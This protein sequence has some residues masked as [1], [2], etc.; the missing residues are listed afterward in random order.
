VEFIGSLTDTI[1]IFVIS[2]SVWYSNYISF[3]DKTIRNKM[4]TCSLVQQTVVFFNV[5][6][7]QGVTSLTMESEY[8]AEQG[9]VY[10][11]FKVPENADFGD[12]KG[13]FVPFKTV[14]GPDGY[15]QEF[16]LAATETHEQEREFQKTKTCWDRPD[17][18]DVPQEEVKMIQ[19]AQKVRTAALSVE[20]EPFAPGRPP[21]Q[22]QQQEEVE[23]SM[24]GVTLDS[25][26]WKLHRGLHRGTQRTLCLGDIGDIKSLNWQD[27]QKILNL[28]QVNSECSQLVSPSTAKK[29][30]CILGNELKITGLKVV[31]VKVECQVDEEK[32]IIS[33][34]ISPYFK[35]EVKGSWQRLIYSKNGITLKGES[36]SFLLEREAY[37]KKQ[38]VGHKQ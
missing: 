20:S 17:A 3:A 33:C 23:N 34:R 9:N 18:G 2:P 10:D 5:F 21:Q 4:P 26:K 27:T 28:D 25:A 38:T 11:L 24:Q 30:A 15:W 8:R 16:H 19:V 7:S 36:E 6:P 22:Q 12:D 29:V 37:K 13:E 14:P 31:K 35:E 1:I 32:N